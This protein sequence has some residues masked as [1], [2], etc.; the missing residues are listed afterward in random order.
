MYRKHYYMFQWTVSSSAS[1][2]INALLSYK[3]I[4]KLVD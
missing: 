1:F 2:K 4:S 3:I